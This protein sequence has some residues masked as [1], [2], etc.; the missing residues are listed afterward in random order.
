MP[1]SLSCPSCNRGL[2]TNEEY[3]G[4]TMKCPNCQ[5]SVTIP[6]AG[7]PAPPPVPD[8]ETDTAFPMGSAEPSA[9]KQMFCTNC[10]S[11]VSEQ[12]F[13]CMSCGAKPTGHKKFCR[14]CG[15]TLNPEQVIC[16]KCGSKIE[17][18][19]LDKYTSSL[20]DFDTNGITTGEAMIFAAAAL[21]FVSFFLPWAEVVLPLVGKLSVK[22][23][24][25]YA[26]LGGIV[27]IYPVWM[28]LTKTRMPSDHIGDFACA[29]I[30]LLF[31]IVHKPIFVSLQLAS[32]ETDRLERAALEASVIGTGTYL[33]LCACIILFIG[34]TLQRKS[35]HRTEND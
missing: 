9:P 6:T 19:G 32:K 23:F 28:A 16:V 21:A 7:G 33:F 4:R 14:H 12:A 31:G 2:H 1:I 15:V 34:I 25:T 8:D 13:A 10:G 17:T 26:F 20:A 11:S 5:S 24:T 30:G 27:F 22:G 3:A 29:G 35:F 18:G